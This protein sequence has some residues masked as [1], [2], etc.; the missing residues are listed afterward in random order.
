MSNRWRE[1]PERGGRRITK[2]Y[3]W[4]C[5]TV[6][7]SR[8]RPILYGIALY[9][10]LSAPLERRAS[11]AYLR[12]VTGRRP[13][14]LGVYRHIFTYST[15]IM[16]RLF[17]LADR[18]EELKL[19]LHGV[20][21][22]DALAETGKGFILASGHLGSF[23]ALRVLAVSQQKL[24]LKILMFMENTQ[25]LNAFLQEINPEIW[26][27]VIPL[28]SP[29]AMLEVKES[30]EKGGIVGILADRI[31]QGDKLT[32]IEFLGAE[33]DFPLGPWLLA[34]VM[35]VP[36]MLCFALYRGRGAYDVH[37]ELLSDRCG[38]DG[39]DRNAAAAELARAYATR[40]EAYCR[41]APYNWFNFF[42]FWAAP[43]AG[44]AESQAPRR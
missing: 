15:V 43:E 8:A 10:F 32:R 11:D 16:D 36:V 31:T 20:E 28:G 39:G 2:F 7:R 12:R 24:P 41:M 30:L 27:S 4:L 5:L 19:N 37:F 1:R 13:G 44:N 38:L 26:E 22:F 29:G 18:A 25:Q 3:I 33:A 35:R 40:L 21:A 14:P 42:D 23:E 9:F 34:G 6:G 17:F